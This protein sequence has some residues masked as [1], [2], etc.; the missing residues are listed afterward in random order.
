M[1][2]VPAVRHKLKEK[3]TSSHLHHCLE[4][5]T[6]ENLHNPNRK[7]VNGEHKVKHK[8]ICVYHHVNGTPHVMPVRVRV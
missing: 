6:D 5:S 4:P 1:E 8:H 2:S 7:K 3:E